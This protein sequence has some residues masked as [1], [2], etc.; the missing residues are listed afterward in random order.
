MY[1]HLITIQLDSHVR[2]V[3]IVIH[4]ILFYKKSLIAQANNKIIEPIMTIYLHYM[5]ENGFPPYL[6]HRLG[7]GLR[8]LGK[9]C[10]QAAGK[11]DCLHYILVIFQLNKGRTTPGISP[12][13]LPD[14]A[15][16][17]SIFSVMV[18]LRACCS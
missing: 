1:I 18:R 2:V 8:F 5:P 11:N 3:H 9:P 10:T 4:E 6:H 7:T 12:A 14:R 15:A 16:E 13:K 17:L